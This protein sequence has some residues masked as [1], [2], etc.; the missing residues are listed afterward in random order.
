M[1]RMRRVGA[2]LKRGAELVSVALLTAM[3]GAFLLQVFSRY[4]LN[5]PLGWTVEACVVFY[6]WT[7][8]W[9]AAFLLRERDH[10]AFTMF[11][12]AVPPP[13]RRVMAIAAAGL[14]GLAFA[15]ALPAIVDYV[16]FMRIDSTPVMR[17]R[18]DFVYAIFPVFAAAVTL[19]SALALR[20]LLGR[21]WRRETG[22]HDETPAAPI[23]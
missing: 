19:R 17:I 20:R 10:V 7:V 16:A 22:D 8:F 12:D 4:V 3:F 5:A 2:L 11:S 1:T 18:F 21:G 15:A 6:L 13:A 23:A 14:V 9:T